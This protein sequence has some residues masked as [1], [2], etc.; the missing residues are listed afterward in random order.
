MRKMNENGSL[1]RL[2]LAAFVCGKGI[3]Q[4]DAAAVGKHGNETTLVRWNLPVDQK[5]F[6]AFASDREVNHVSGFPRTDKERRL[7]A[8]R[9]TL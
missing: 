4:N 8:Y 6:D 2:R 1:A 9:I 7:F 3:N 5:L